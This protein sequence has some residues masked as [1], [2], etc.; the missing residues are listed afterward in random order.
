MSK[1][2][3]PSIAARLSEATAEVLKEACKSLKGRARRLFMAKTVKELG[4]GGQYAAEKELGWNRGTIRKGMHE[5][6]TGIS[7][8]DAFNMRGRKSYIE[9]LPCLLDDIREIAEHN[10]QTDATF[11]TTK[12]YLRLTAA[13]FVRQLSERKGYSE[14]RLPK[15]RTMSNILNQLGYR[16]RKVKKTAP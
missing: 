16:L 8:I 2:P 15:R 4:A 5:L 13:Q 10:T 9:V 7:S 11:R 3:V 1:P 6:A 12:L 14:E